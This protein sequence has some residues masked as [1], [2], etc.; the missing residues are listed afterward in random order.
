MRSIVEAMGGKVEV[1]SKIG[2]GAVFRIHLTVTATEPLA[3]P[4]SRLDAQQKLPPSQHLRVLVADDNRVNRMVLQGLL[5]KVDCETHF[6]ENGVQ[7]VNSVSQNTYDL[8][9]MDCFMPQMDGFEATKK[10]R[11]DLGDTAPIIVAITASSE[12]ADKER[13]MEAGMDGFLSKPIRSSSIRALFTSIQ[14]GDLDGE[15]SAEL[16]RHLFHA[17]RRQG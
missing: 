17:L 14:G 4:E 10:I 1:E 6:V 3:I 2:E 11:K 13:C 15:A 5:K 9:L 16:P 7:A 12:E 8:V